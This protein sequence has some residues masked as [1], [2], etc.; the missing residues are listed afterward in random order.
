MTEEEEE[1][2]ALLDEERYM[3][4]DKDILEEDLLKGMF[5]N[6]KLKYHPYVCI[7]NLVTKEPKG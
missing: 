7:C 6:T 1:F 3:A 4:L 5:S 2:E